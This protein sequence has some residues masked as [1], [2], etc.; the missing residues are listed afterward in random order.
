LLLTLAA[1]SLLAPFA[2]AQVAASFAQLN[3]C[4]RDP[5]RGVLDQAAMSLRNLNTNQEFRT[6]TNSAGIYAFP[7]LPPGSYRL[8]ASF[9][10]FSTGYRDGLVLMVGQTATI[11]LELSLETRNDA[12]TVDAEATPIDAGRTEISDVI[13]GRQIEALPN[14]GRLFTDFALL[15][16]GVA[17]GRTSLQSAVT[18]FEVT[19]V[20]FGGMRD[21]SNQVMVDGADAINTVTGSQRATPPQDSVSEFRMVANS[22]G[23]DYGRALGGIVN[24]VTK[25]G[26][27]VFHGALYEFFENNALNARSLL[28]PSPDPDT[29]RQNQFGAAFGGPVIKNRTFFFANYEGQRR[30]LSPTFPAELFD[31]LGFFNAAKRALGLAPENLNILQTG[32][33]DRGFFKLDH[34]FNERHRLSIRYNVEAG[35]SLNLLAG[36]TVDG[37]GVAAPSDGHNAYVLDSSLVGNLT[38]TRGANLVNTFLAQVARRSYNFPGVNGQPALDIPNELVFG[39]NFGVFDFVGEM[40]VQLSNATSWVHGRHIV[41]FGGDLNLLSDHVT[42]PGFTP[43]RIVLPGGNCLAQFADYVDPSAKLAAN[44]ALAPCP[45]PPSLNGTPVVFWGTPVGSGPLTPGYVPPAIPTTWGNAY[46]PSTTGAFNES[47]THQYEGLFIEDQWKVSNRLTINYGLRWD[48]ETGLENAIGRDYSNFGPRIGLAFAPG[49]KTVIRAGFGIFY[50]RFS[51]P[52]VFVT[53]PERPVVIPGVT[54][55]GVGKNSA[56]AGWILNQLTPGPGGLPADVAKTLILS[57]RVPAQYLTGPCPPSCT[58]GAALIDHNSRTPYAEQASFQI[59]REIATG[60]TAGI[61]YLLASAHHQVRAENLNVSQPAGVLPDGKALFNGPIYPNAGLLYYTD[62]SGNAI[63]HGL[64]AQISQRYRHSMSFNANFTLSKTLDDGTFTTFVSTP[65]DLYQ[66]N[67]E[68]AASNQDVRKRFVS[69]FTVDGPAKTILRKFQLSGIVTLQSGRPFT[70]FVG[71][72]ANGDTN[73]V[74]DRVGQSA[75][76][77]Y[78][79]DEL[80]ST[81]LRLSRYFAVTE[82]SR[83]TIS[84]DAFNAF[85]RANVEEVNSVY[86]YADFL[87]PVPRNYGDGVGSPANPLFG[88]P[89]TMSNPRWLQISARLTF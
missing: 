53:D 39:H 44:P 65:Q 34:E 1:A 70:L 33:R 86:G 9:A 30:A 77:T 79:G 26:T 71:Y 52:F 88:T 85:N 55:P 22:F 31:N 61:G 84:I 45:L 38:S 3:G 19:R 73:P 11:N 46:L 12:V 47:L 72:D 68:R 87:G 42:W 8:E 4:V 89:R 43:M 7:S 60:L 5:N 15:T 54:L 59:D 36:N 62:N 50:D 82:H 24:I 13:S 81:D 57:G 6:V 67:L 10:K 23:A 16:P 17:T 78:Y 76:N 29:L 49:A 41:R 64:T 83:M 80:Y 37:G 74:T 66:R 35:Q 28:Q 51:L 48:L 21:L 32:D 14:S 27:N 25:S 20:S 75:R 69:S 2:Y 56:T 18:E 40:R 58:A 63:Y